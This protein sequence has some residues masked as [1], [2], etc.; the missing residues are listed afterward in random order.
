MKQTLKKI[1]LVI[2]NKL[3]IIQLS[4]N[5]PKTTIFPHLHGIFISPKAV[6]G[7]NC[8]IYQNVTIGS[9]GINNKVYP[10]IGNNVTIYSHV[11]VVGNVTI[12]DNSV[13]GAGTIVTKSFPPNSV[14]IGNP[15]RLL[16]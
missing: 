6:I 13:I 14:I 9:K 16:K 11:C 1:R 3:F 7:D 5:I 8:I 12:G 10:I 2:L 4:K 15:G